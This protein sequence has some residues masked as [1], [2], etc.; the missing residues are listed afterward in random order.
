LLLVG[1]RSFTASDPSDL[2]VAEKPNEIDAVPP[3]PTTVRIL[4]GEHPYNG[5]VFDSQS[6]LVLTTEEVTTKK[7]LQV[8]FPVLTDGKVLVDSKEWKT[9]T[10]STKGHLVFADERRNLAVVQVDSV[11]EGMAEVKLA[12]ASPEKGAT[13]QLLGNSESATQIWS[14]VTTTIRDV[15]TRRVTADADSVPIQALM[16]ELGIDGKR[17]HRVTGGAV[18]NAS[19][20]LVG[21]IGQDALQK[22]LLNCIDVTEV[23]PVLAAAY[24][25]F[26]GH[27]MIRGR[28][29]GAID[30]CNKAL[31]LLDKDAWTY[32][33][34]GAAY[35]MM[36]DFDKAI[37]DYT[38]ALELD[39]TLAL[40]YRNRG[41]AYLSKGQHKEA[42]ADCT[43]AI[44]LQPRFILAYHTRGQAYTKL[45]M[46][47]EAD[48]D[49]RWVAELT[50]TDWRVTE[51]SA[52]RDSRLPSLPNIYTQPVQPSMPIG[53]PA[54]PIDRPDWWRPN[55]DLPPRTW[56]LR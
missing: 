32:N 34:R 27:A 51:V 46:K 24:R 28:H 18:V 35:S 40:A 29:A 38:R 11:P 21:V 53:R 47:K 9:R 50:K 55:I 20:E 36:E 1:C 2:D 33:Q 3:L 8:F 44:D 4:V 49:A 54:L 52:N 14:P 7:E 17:A 48:T 39:K 26:A 10:Q 23:R 6:G 31:A 19:Q 25:R 12:A 41:S 15:R 37:A 45:N 42:V 16:S 30:Y 43:A 22:K 5:V 13:V 56:R